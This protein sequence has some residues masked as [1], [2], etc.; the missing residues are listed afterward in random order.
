MEQTM[1]AGQGLTP[2]QKQLLDLVSQESYFLK[3]FYLSGGTALSSWYFHHRESF[4]LDFFSLV[5]FE[6]DRIIR[7]FRQNKPN[8][9]YTNARFDEDYGF[10]ITLLQYPNAAS[11]KIDFHHYSNKKL[12]S[13]IRWHG[14][15]IDSLIDIAV[16]KLQ[17]IATTPRTR[18]Y[19]DLY[20]IL[21]HAKWSLKQL[22]KKTETK[23]EEKIDMLQLAKNFLKVSE[24]TDFPNMIIPF[25]VNVMYQ[26]YENLTKTLKSMVLT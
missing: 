25:D 12:S 10:L 16:N 7:W 14:M 24:Y 6:Y 20:V 8:I 9:G 17:T 21:S 18:D 19:I 4:D 26:F 1:V 11:L 13:G 15:E 22:I 23:F 3:N 2:Q 5:P